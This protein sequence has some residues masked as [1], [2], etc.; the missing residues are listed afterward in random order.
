MTGADQETIEIFKN[1]R[2][3][4]YACPFWSSLKVQKNPQNVLQQI[5]AKHKY[6]TTPSTTGLR[7]AALHLIGNE[8]NLRIVPDSSKKVEYGNSGLYT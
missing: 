6:R 1:L 7:E 4:D 3:A 8:E 5:R 2:S